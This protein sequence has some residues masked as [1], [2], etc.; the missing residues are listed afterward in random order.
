MIARPPDADEPADGSDTALPGTA[1]IARRP[2]RP[3][4]CSPG[5]ELSAALEAREALERAET[6]R[7]ALV[8]GSHAKS[9]REA[10]EADWRGFVAWCQRLSPADPTVHPLPASDATLSLWLAAHA[11]LAPATLAR[12]LSAVRLKHA[13]EGCPLDDAA[14]PGTRATLRGH[15]LA[16][17]ERPSRRAAAATEDVL[18]AM[19]AAV[20]ASGDLPGGRPE[21]GR[22]A[23][24]TLSPMAL[25]DRALLLVGY[26]SGLRRAE[27]S[28]MRLEHLE[29]TRVGVRVTLPF[30]KTDQTGKGAWVAM[31]ARPG[32]TL[33]P[34]AAL[35]AWCAT[36]GRTWGPVFVAVR[37]AH[38]TGEPGSRA[39]STKSIGRVVSRAAARAGLAGRF[40]AHSLRRGI[41]TDAI[42]AGVPLHRLQKHVRHVHPATTLAYVE[43]RDAEANH[44]RGSRRPTEALPRADVD[45]EHS[46]G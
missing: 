39:L 32:S 23:G 1:S 5:D 10:Y 15:A 21:A 7:A 37:R 40:G 38:H 43:G 6:A 26:D 17:R 4:G 33:C 41:I 24:G 30:A 18:E 36:L 31:I 34:V 16:A 9:T 2:S 28:A 20:T 25:R 27:L 35:D 45:R 13:R 14:L 8:S 44:P 29:R 42:E 12:R 3:N 19:V 46:D 11:H 22:C